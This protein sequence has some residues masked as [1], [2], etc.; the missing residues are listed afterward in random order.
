MRRIFFST[1]QLV[2]QIKYSVNCNEENRELKDKTTKFDIVSPCAQTAPG[3]FLIAH[4]H[5]LSKKNRNCGKCSFGNF[6][7]LSW[8]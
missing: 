6:L 4:K 7:T 1:F 8:N 2:S 3:D 5:S